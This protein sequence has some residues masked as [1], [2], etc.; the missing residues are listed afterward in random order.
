MSE[1]KGRWL[2]GLV[3]VV[4]AFLA[5]PGSGWRWSWGCGARAGAA[6]PTEPADAP[7]EGLEGEPFVAGGQTGRVAA[8]YVDRH[9][10]VTWRDQ[11]VA[12]G[13]AAVGPVETP[14]V[15]ASTDAPGHWPSRDWR[16]W[17]MTGG[18]GAWE[19]RIPLESARTPVV[20][21]VEAGAGSTN[22]SAMRWFRPGLAGVTEPTRPFTGHLEGFEQGLGGW[23]WG[24]S[25]D[26]AMGMTTS[27]QAWTGRAALRLEVPRGRA[28]ATIG[29][30]RLRGW[31]LVEH[32]PVNLVMAARTES[33]VGKLRLALHGGARSDDLA[34]YPARR[35]FEVGPA[36][37]RIEVPLE[38]FVNLRPSTVDWLTVQ[39]LADGGRAVLLDDVELELR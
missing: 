32:A 35:E 3:W 29:T 7:L 22:V 33:G 2:R 26:G 24:G 25:G 6:E 27:S 16:A 1:V 28:S 19:A 10:R 15:L 20:Y 5:S 36:W 34:V 9:L 13:G 21:F 18:K 14:R 37:R 38:S 31:M 39:F 12:E 17:P 8:A 4:L 23:E 30:V 11:T